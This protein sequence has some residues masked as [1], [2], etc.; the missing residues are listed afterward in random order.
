MAYRRRAL[1]LASL[2]LAIR[3]FQSRREQDQKPKRRFCVR[4]S[5]SDERKER[6]EWQNLFFLSLVRMI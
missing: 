6:S 4:K 2:A 3:H 1:I 5:F